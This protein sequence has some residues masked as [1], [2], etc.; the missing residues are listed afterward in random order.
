MEP[1]HKLHFSRT[2]LDFSAADQEAMP[3]VIIKP[4]LKRSVKPRFQCLHL[5]A[6]LTPVWSEAI[7]LR[8]L[9][10]LRTPNITERHSEEGGCLL[11]SIIQANVPDK[12]SLSPR[13]CEGILRRANARG[14]ALPPILKEALEARAAE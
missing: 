11:S 4:C 1:N 14:K 8:S 9:G 12:Y 5:D 10:S 2:S 3:G 6:G 13:A 7:E